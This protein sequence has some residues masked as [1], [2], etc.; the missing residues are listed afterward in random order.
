MRGARSQSV[1]RYAAL[2]ARE[3]AAMLLPCLITPP[4]AID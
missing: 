1:P 2:R 3:R 4:I